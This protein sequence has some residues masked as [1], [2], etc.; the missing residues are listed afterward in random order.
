M[1]TEF[2]LFPL[3]QSQWVP[4]SDVSFC[5]ICDQPF[6]ST[7]FTSGK[8]HCRKCGKV[9]CDDCSK[10]RV[11][12]YRVC[13]SCYQPGASITD[14]L[15]RP[16]TPYQ[17]PHPLSSNNSYIT[18]MGDNE[19]TSYEIE[20]Y[21]HHDDVKQMRYKHST[22]RSSSSSNSHSDHSHAFCDECE[23]KKERK[24]LRKMEKKARKERKKE[25]KMEQKLQ[26]KAAKYQRKMAK[27]QAKMMAKQQDFVPSYTVYAVHAK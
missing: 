17:P 3:P 20:G 16:S 15:K 1:S 25:L 22:S 26:R 12:S 21:S 14:Y 7:L 9:I 5:T 4:D 11:Q 8:H 10:S 18:P 6:Q 27:K 19:D 2:Q 23:R 24:R 13:D